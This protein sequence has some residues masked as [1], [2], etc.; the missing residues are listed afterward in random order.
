LIKGSLK[1][2]IKPKIFSKK[3]LYLELIKAIGMMFLFKK[4]KLIKNRIFW[5]TILFVA[6]FSV[7]LNLQNV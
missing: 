5:V 7:L 3:K 4:Q 1:S 2:L 6:S